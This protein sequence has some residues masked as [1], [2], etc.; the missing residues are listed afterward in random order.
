MPA[1]KI[2]PEVALQPIE[3]L[4]RTEVF[5]DIPADGLRWLAAAAHVRQF[6]AGAVL[7]RQG[8]PAPTL[9]VVV[10]GRVRIVEAES[11]LPGGRLELA[12]LGPGE[13]V[14]E[15]GVLDGAPRSATV[16]A[17][18]ATTT[19]ELPAEAIAVAI[20]QYPTVTAALLR[21]VSQ[22]LRSANELIRRLA[23]DKGDWSGP[24]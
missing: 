6:D 17:V 10:A 18:E 1:P 7:M 14:G 9:H 22:R 21:T 12:L 16:T 8:D 4:R 13:V 23:E 24:W 19:L 11:V 5:R 20:V 15:M 2:E 3:V